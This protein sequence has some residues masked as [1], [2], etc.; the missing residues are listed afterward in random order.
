MKG[1][2]D[3]EQ[4]ALKSYKGDDP[5]EGQQQVLGRCAA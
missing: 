5:V 2:G 4:W 1:G 3:K